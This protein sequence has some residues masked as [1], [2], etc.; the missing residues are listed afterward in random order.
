M[1]NILVL[2]QPPISKNENIGRFRTTEIYRGPTIGQELGKGF[3][4]HSFV[5][6]LT[7]A[8]RM[9]ETPG[10]INQRG[11]D[12]GVIPGGMMTKVNRKRPHRS[13]PCLGHG[14]VRASTTGQE[15]RGKLIGNGKLQ[16]IRGVRTTERHVCSVEAIEQLKCSRTWWLIT[17]RQQEQHTPATP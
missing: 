13:A 1:A 5:S 14:P 15:K 8:R 12:N 17:L 10:R 4:A 3:S 11:D 16:R 2:K 7:N 6:R 9:N